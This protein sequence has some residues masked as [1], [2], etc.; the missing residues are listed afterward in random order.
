MKKINSEN[1]KLYEKRLI[2]KYNKIIEED[3]NDYFSSADNSQ[4]SGSDFGIDEDEEL[5]CAN[6]KKNKINIK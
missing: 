4:I 1:Q 5:I 3:I 6:I 2:K